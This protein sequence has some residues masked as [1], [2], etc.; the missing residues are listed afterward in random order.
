MHN[1]SCCPLN[2][3]ETLFCLPWRKSGFHSYWLWPVTANEL[4][5]STRCPCQRAYRDC[6]LQ[7]TTVDGGQIHTDSLGAVDLMGRGLVFKPKALIS[8]LLFI[9][10]SCWLLLN[11]WNISVDIH[12]NKAEKKNLLSFYSAAFFLRFIAVCDPASDLIVRDIFVD[13]FIVYF[14]TQEHITSATTLLN[15]YDIYKTSDG[16]KRQ[17][18]N[19]K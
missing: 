10:G 14:Q 7:G 18:V 6:L 15:Q 1:N 3:Y 2:L 9:L 16:S 17:K 19:N 12:T 8:N 5:Q 13:H 4:R 11:S